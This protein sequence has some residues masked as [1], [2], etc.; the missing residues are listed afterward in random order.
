[1]FAWKDKSIVNLIVEKS[2][3]VTWYTY[4]DEVFSRVPEFR[5]YHWLISDLELNYCPDPRLQEDPV[6]IDGESLNEILKTHKVQFI[7]A[8][9][10]GFKEKI[11]ALPTKLPYA[12]GNRELLIGCPKPQALGSEVEIVCWD[13]T[14]TL[15]IGVDNSIAKKL[16]DIYPDI[17]DLD[18]EN[19]T[20]S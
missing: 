16:R 7:W 6:I 14:C 17:R 12:D 10:S 15:F 5:H 19:R 8:V 13:S 9:L 2:K 11:D 18:V 4:L 1:M 20:R 3:Y